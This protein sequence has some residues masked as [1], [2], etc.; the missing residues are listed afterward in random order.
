MAR[1]LVS[2]RRIPIFGSMSS[3]APRPMEVLL[4][5]FNFAASVFDV[6]ELA[7]LMKQNGLRRIVVCNDKGKPVG[8]VS[9]EDMAC[10]G[11]DKRLVAEALHRQMI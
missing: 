4:S 7:H 8:I 6:E 2:R 1:A 3:V 11:A 5:S 9:L 10:R